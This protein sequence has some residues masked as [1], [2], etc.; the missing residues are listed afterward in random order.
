[1]PQEGRPLIVA[2]LINAKYAR[3]KTHVFYAWNSFRILVSSIRKNTAYASITT[4]LRA[5]GCDCAGGI[6]FEIR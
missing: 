3:V 5:T 6:A 1:M 4:K 2:G